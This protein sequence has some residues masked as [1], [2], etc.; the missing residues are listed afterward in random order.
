MAERDSS[1]VHSEYIV[2]LKYPYSDGSLMARPELA[3]WM[4]AVDLDILEVLA[5][6]GAPRDFVA[7]PRVIA[8]NTTWDSQTVRDHM[9]RLRDGN[10]V[11][12]YDEGDGIYQLSDL[13][14][15]YLARAV[16]PSEIPDPTE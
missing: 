13:G 14:A 1:V 15:Q 10:L 16:D 7:N 3:D 9:K 12:Y 8:A 4:T 11:E 2:G 5:N 6:P